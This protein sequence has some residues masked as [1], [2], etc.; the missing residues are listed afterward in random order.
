MTKEVGRPTI[1][2]RPLQS[3]D[4]DI[5]LRELVRALVEDGRQVDLDLGNSDDRF[6]LEE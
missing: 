5:T 2:K 6:V 4:D 1:N 3:G